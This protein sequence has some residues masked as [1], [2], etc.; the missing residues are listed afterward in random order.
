MPNRCYHF[1]KG[2]ANAH[3][4]TPGD[5]GLLATLP[6]AMIGPGTNLYQG[7][8]PWTWDWKERSPL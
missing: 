3:V 1:A 4:A 8:F 2:I 7:V 5:S 6:T